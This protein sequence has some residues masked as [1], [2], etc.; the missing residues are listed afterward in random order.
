MSSEFFD[1]IFPKYLAAWFTRLNES[2]CNLGSDDFEE[3][4]FV[5][6][7]P[8]FRLVHASPKDSIEEKPDMNDVPMEDN[9]VK[10]SVS[11]SF[12]SPPKL[13]SSP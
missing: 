9:Q 11:N 3:F 4:E 12:I 8:F 1:S 10:L 13:K 2:L 7:N 6:S 5:W